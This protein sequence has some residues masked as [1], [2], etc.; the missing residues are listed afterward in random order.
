[1]GAYTS[2]SPTTNPKV[3][4]TPKASPESTYSLPSEIIVI[5]VVVV[6]VVIGIAVFAL[7][8]RK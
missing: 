1:M 8:K 6:L 3:D 5:V 7:K 2:P 4:L